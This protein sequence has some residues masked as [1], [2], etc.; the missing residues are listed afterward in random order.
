MRLAPSQNDGLAGHFAISSDSSTLLFSL[1][2]SYRTRSSSLLNRKPNARNIFELPSSHL[3]SPPQF[4]V[5]SAPP[6]M[7]AMLPWL[8]G[9][10][11]V[12]ALAWDTQC[13]APNGEKVH[14]KFSPCIA[15]EG[16]IS[17]CCR[18][19][20]THPD[21]CLKNGLCHLKNDKKEEY[22]RNYCNDRDWN[23]PNCLKNVCV[24]DKVLLGEL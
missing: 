13:Y 11:S 1:P 17:M 4:R 14:P 23:S 2:R 10:F 12:F 8:L 18:I 6:T 24:D 16:E 3:A 9:A 20:D 7:I 22:Y 19:N 15:V 5:P 21:V